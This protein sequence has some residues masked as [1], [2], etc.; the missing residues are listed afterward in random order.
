MPEKDMC[1]RCR[2]L[3]GWMSFQVAGVMHRLC[4]PCTQELGRFLA[5]CQTGGTTHANLDL[6][7]AYPGPKDSRTCHATPRDAACNSRVY[8]PDKVHCAHIPSSAE[9]HR[10][11]GM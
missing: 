3:P 9:C 10:A 7:K 2:Q 6:D 1:E 8:G 4:K 5:G 11:R